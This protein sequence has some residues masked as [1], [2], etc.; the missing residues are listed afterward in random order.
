MAEMGAG[1]ATAECS[2]DGDVTR[3]P[4]DLKIKS[5]PPGR[6]SALRVVPHALV[7]LLRV[8]EPGNSARTVCSVPRVHLEPLQPRLHHQQT[9]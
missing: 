5:C 3:Y 4:E 1:V 9:S 8:Q 2:E 7:E 6:I